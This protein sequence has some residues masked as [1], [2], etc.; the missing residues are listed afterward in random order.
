MKYTETN[1]AL[2][3]LELFG[4]LNI[5]KKYEPNKFIFAEAY[6]WKIKINIYENN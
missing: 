4:R 5:I 2:T 6:E 1:L 3:M